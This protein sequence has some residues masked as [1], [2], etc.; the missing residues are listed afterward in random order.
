V[1]AAAQNIGHFAIECDD[2]ER[3]KVFYETVFGW[4]IKPWGPP[5]YYLI[6]TGTPE[7]PGILGDLRERHH[8]LGGAGA[9]VSGYICTINVGNLKAVLAAV[10]AR[11][12]RIHSPPYLIEN[13]GT[14]A[15]V[16]DSEGNRV[17]LM[18][19]V[20]NPQMPESVKRS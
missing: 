20:G 6:T 1:T 10:E 14:V 7:H 11:G 9:G 8:K 15:Y 17:G 19:P 13:V 4:T 16:E 12:G 2:V 18:Q 3:A 5:N